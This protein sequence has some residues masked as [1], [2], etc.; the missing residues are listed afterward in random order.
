MNGPSTPGRSRWAGLRAPI[1][2]CGVGFGGFF[3]GIV[4][5]QVLQWHHMLSNTGSDRIGLAARPVTTVDGL[6][7]NTLWDGLFHAFTYLALLVGVI[8]TWHRWSRGPAVPP[9]WRLF[10]G[11]LLVGWGSFNVVEGVINHHLLAIHHV[12]AGE[13]QLVADLVFLGVGAAMIAAGVHLS[14]R[15]IRGH[16][17][18]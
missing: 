10:V 18:G 12:R 13:G 3:D 5:H 1:V 7:V 11:S 9:P 6:E 14:E 4:F 16:R 8:W 17:S 15:S 2:M